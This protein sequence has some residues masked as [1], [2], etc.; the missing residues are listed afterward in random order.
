[1]SANGL[2]ILTG[3]SNPRFA[4][5]MARYLGVRVSAMTC[6]RFSDGEIFVEIEENIR[7][8]DV[9]IIQSTCYPVNDN[10]MELLIIMD[11]VKRAS[12]GRITVV[13]PYFGY[14]RQDRKVAP[15]TPISS[16][17]V[18]DL[19]ECA[20]AS[21]VLTMDLHAGQIQGF[22]NIPVDHMYFGSA[23]TPT[24]E[25]YV[26][27]DATVLVSPDAGGVERARHYAK[28]FDC[29][30]AVIDKRRDAPNVVGEMRIIGDVA[31]KIAILLDDLIDTAGT[32]TKAAT[33]LKENQ[34][35]KVYACCTHPVLSGPAI[36]RIEKS[37][38][39][40]LIVSD[41]IPLRD[42][43]KKCRKIQVVS[44]AKVLGEAV[45]RIH[46]SE[47]VSSLFE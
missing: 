29:E 13:L 30:L 3:N 41:S 9:F 23:V 43:A 7:G 14:A 25:R 15:R 28:K 6:K 39:A 42:E 21:R 1:M 27:P 4:K 18:A 38:L 16:K 12:A 24:L 34:A 31:G 20:G 2:T 47:S 44:T 10:L 26:K 36:E 17:L 22:F 5:A 46:N 19:I 11:A 32:L 33:A 37:E 8:R 40:K 45:R 35:T